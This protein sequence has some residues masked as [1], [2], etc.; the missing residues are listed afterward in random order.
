M[1]VRGRRRIFGKDAEM[2]VPAH[3]RVLDRSSP[4]REVQIDGTIRPSDAPIDITITDLSETGFGAV[5]DDLPLEHGAYVAIG[6]QSLGV[7]NARVIWSEGARHGFEFVVPLRPADVIEA[8]DAD[9]VVAI[10]AP[11]HAAI[12]EPPFPDPEVAKWPGW[13]RVT[14]ILALGA[15]GWAA[16][17]MIL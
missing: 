17:M 3:L 12:F 10:G 14:L 13:I 11:S 5:L 1:A 4:R 7:R 6:T 8:K 16:L 9:N 15:A 2:G